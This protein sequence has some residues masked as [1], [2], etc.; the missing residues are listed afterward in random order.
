VIANGQTLIVSSPFMRV[1]GAGRIGALPIPIL[2]AG[3]I[4]LLAILVIRYT[5]FGRMVYAVGGNAE[6]S[7]LAGI[8]VTAIRV[9]TYAIGAGLS[10][11]AG[12]LQTAT[13]IS[14]SSAADS[15]ILLTA[16][17]AVFL[18]GTSFA[19]GSGS[20]FGT[21]LGVLFL[22]LLQNG[23]LISAVSSYWQGIITGAILFLSVG[24]D[25]Y[26]R[27]PDRSPAIPDA[28]GHRN[29]A[30]ASKTLRPKGNA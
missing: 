23:L 6:A 4:L 20:M 16:A 24:L 7:R 3:V 11:V 28:A 26:R 22:S 15:Q 9:V 13:L 8:P 19:G 5:G 25:W 10:A 12:V 17:A 30:L 2:V 29:V 14:A 1:L 21:F 27:R 18:G